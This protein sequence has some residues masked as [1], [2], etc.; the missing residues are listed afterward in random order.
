[1]EPFKITPV[2]KPMKIRLLNENNEG[3]VKKE[4]QKTKA[5]HFFELYVLENRI[6]HLPNRS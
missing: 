1:M 4:G 3:S 5:L 6:Y 2:L